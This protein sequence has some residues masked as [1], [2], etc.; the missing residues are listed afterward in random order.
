VTDGVRVRFAPSPTGQLHVGGARTAL[1]NWLFAR[2]QGGTFILRIEDTD[3]SRSTDENIELIVDALRWLGLDWDEGPPTAGYRQTER[4]DL[5]REHAARLVKAGRAYYCDCPPEQLEAERRAA[6]ARKETFRYPGRCRERGLTAGAL[7]LRIPDSGAT[8]VHDLIHGP[9]TFEHRQLDDWILVRTDGTPTYNFCVVVDDVTMRI[10]HVIRGN[11]HLSN[12]PKQ[13][14]CYEALDYQVPAFAHV[15]MILGPDRARLSKRHGATSV[16]AYR[17]QGILPEAMVNYLARLGWSHGDQEIFTRAELVERFDIKDV[18]SAG[19][20][21]DQAKLEWL[22]H[23]Y[24]K[25][26]DGAR[27]AV[28]VRPFLA[29][30]G[31]TAPD[32]DRLAAMLETLRERARTLRELVEA[33]RFYLER[34]ASYEDAARARLL[35]PAGAERLD[36]LLARLGAVEPFAPPALEALYRELA[37]ALGLKLVDL[38]QLTRLAVTGRTASPPLFDVLALLGRSEVLARLQAARAVAGRSA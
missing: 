3:R 16:Q 25:A 5:Y 8:V 7:R 18:S 19:A 28:L 2:H 24:I 6:E 32:D 4:L 20:V 33:G 31:L 34:P 29:E 22:S 10:S 23:E 27:L 15:S 21:F 11:D 36:L 14:L 37:A 30:A 35:T 26:S 13:V 12:T 1:F 9:V 38:A 17:E